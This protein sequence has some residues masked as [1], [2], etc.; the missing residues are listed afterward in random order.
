MPCGFHGASHIRQP[1]DWIAHGDEDILGVD[2]VELVQG[3]TG[4]GI[5]AIVHVV[6][7]VAHDKGLHALVEG[8][9]LDGAAA[10]IRKLEQRSP[11][12]REIPIGTGEGDVQH[13]VVFCR[14][15]DPQSTHLL[16]YFGH[17]GVVGR[18]VDKRIHKLVHHKAIAVHQTAVDAFDFFLGLLFLQKAFD[19]SPQ[20]GEQL[21]AG[22]RFEQVLLHAQGDGL[23]RIGKIVIA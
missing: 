6:A 3:G 4:K 8:T 15:V 13:D 2:G 17:I 19:N 18:V 14:Q 22:N 16:A 7:V 20:H 23:L 11:A 1:H 21:A 10:V 5:G 12:G 9:Q